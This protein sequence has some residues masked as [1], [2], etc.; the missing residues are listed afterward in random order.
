[1]IRTL[2]PFLMLISNPHLLPE[3]GQLP[4][5]FI[6]NVSAMQG[7]AGKEVPRRM[8]RPQ[9]DY[10]QVP[11]AAGRQPGEWGAWAEEAGT[12]VF[13]ASLAFKCK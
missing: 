10:R 2:L 1:M 7:A 6:L 13:P 5:L 11:G 3:L 9:T 4:L 8:D 12:A